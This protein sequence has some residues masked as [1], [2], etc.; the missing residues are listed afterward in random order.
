M[1]SAPRLSDRSSYLKEMS[2][3]C[4]SVQVCLSPPCCGHREADSGQ[5]FLGDEAFSTPVKYL[6]LLQRRGEKR[7]F[8]IRHG[9]RIPKKKR[10]YLNVKMKER[11]NMSASD[12]QTFTGYNDTSVNL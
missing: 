4:W 10:R 2:T 7:F 1:L 8:L 6:T 3:N 12:F 11:H 9:G 5:L